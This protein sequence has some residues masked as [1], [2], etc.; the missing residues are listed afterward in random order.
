M[1]KEGNNKR[2]EL[3]EFQRYVRGEMTKREE[4]AFRKRS[5]NDPFADE[6]IESP[7]EISYFKTSDVMIPGGKKFN[8]RIRSGKRTVLYVSALVI[9]LV[10][11]ATVFVILYRNNTTLQPGKNITIPAPQEATVS[12]QDPDPVFSGS[13]QAT[14]TEVINEKQEIPDVNKTGISSISTENTGITDSAVYPAKGEEKDPTSPEPVAGSI[15]F[16]KYIDENIIRPPGIPQGEDAVAIVSFVV[17]T[18][19]I[20]DSIKVISSPGD[21]FAKE[22]IRLIR[23]GPAWKPAV[24]NGLPIDDEVRLRIV[25]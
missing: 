25:F 2:R 8:K 5:Q 6:A 9:I 14:D 21:E 7:S 22:A 11:I 4:N 1:K 18:T 24:N 10:I 23:E 16:K 20:P 15:E 3:S 12:D 13:D 19:G 17:R